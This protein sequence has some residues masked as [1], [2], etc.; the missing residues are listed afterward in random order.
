M[1][2]VVAA[3]L[4]VLL[5]QPALALDARPSEDSVNRLFEVMHTSQLLDNY[6]AQVDG[7]VGRSV[8]DS[9]QGAQLS[10]EE[11][12]ILADMRAEL[13]SLIKQEVSWDSIRPLMIEVYRNTFTQHEVDAMLKFYESPV[14]QAVTAKLPAAMNQ[15][16]Q[17]M[18]ERV[19]A[20]TPRLLQLQ[21][22]TVA[23]L[24][25]AHDRQAAAP[26]PGD[27]QPAQ[28]PSPAH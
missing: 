20:L 8:R 7:T 10:A 6:L 4:A 19:S 22:E 15:G 28:T 3:L 1:R 13:Q 14:G 12:Q 5:W 27:S 26:P 21:R 16:M 2:V 9:L 25:R 24:K 17:A 11:Q 18:Q 23:A